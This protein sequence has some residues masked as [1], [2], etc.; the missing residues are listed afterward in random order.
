M[1]KIMIIRHAEKPANGGTDR[2]VCVDGFHSKHELTVR[3]WQRAAAL[4][5]FFAPTHA[6]PEGHPISE[7]KA[8]FAAGT[9][10]DSPSLRAQRTVEPL[11]H[12]LGLPIELSFEEYQ[13]DRLAVAVVAA[14]SP[15]LIAWHH[16]SIP[17][18]ARLIAGTGPDIP[19]SW[20]EERY[21][22]VWVLDR[23]GADGAWTFSKIAQRLFAYDPGE[24]F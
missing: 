8:I 16:H 13:E 6:R 1:Q 20:P 24:P 3:G 5:P 10:E 9:N 19:A 4:V 2:S 12:A 15:V 23:A 14:Q 11:A 18:L 22:V 7:P 21:D 17:L